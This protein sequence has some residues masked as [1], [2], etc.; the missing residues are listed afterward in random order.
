MGR[1]QKEPSR[2]NHRPMETE[3]S[4]GERGVPCYH[5]ET[6]KAYIF[7]QR[8][9]RPIWVA[10]PGVFFQKISASMHLFRVSESDS[11]DHT[12]KTNPD[13]RR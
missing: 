1:V 2:R 11:D 9:I 4:A 8:V 7:A 13:L 6:M 5:V 3:V 12:C 10:G